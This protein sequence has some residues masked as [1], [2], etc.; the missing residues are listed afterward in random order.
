MPL[1]WQSTT[2]SSRHRFSCLYRKCNKGTI[3]S[4]LQH[5]SPKLWCYLIGL[6]LSR[7]QWNSTSQCFINFTELKYYTTWMTNASPPLIPPLHRGCDRC[8]SLVRPH[9]QITGQVA[10]ERRTEAERLSWSF[11][12]GTQD[13]QTSPWTPR[14]PWSFEHVQNSRTKVAEEVG[15]SQVAQKR[16]E[17]G[18]RIAVVVEWT[19]GGRPLVA[20]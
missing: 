4:S 10:V 1:L 15:R 6:F 19:H 8:A 20:P 11:K 7:Y 12:G 5:F 3:I 16:Q 13:V 9:N 18:T 17:E 14:S 2:A